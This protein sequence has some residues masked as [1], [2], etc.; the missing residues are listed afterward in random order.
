MSIEPQRIYV[1]DNFEIVKY[2]S[3]LIRS[4]DSLIDKID[5]YLK[6]SKDTIYNLNH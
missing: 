6:S 2:G 5:I 4:I 1:N 3:G